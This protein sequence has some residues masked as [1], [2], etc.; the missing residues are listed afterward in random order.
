MHLVKRVKMSGM[1]KVTTAFALLALS[2]LFAPGA[3]HAASAA[4]AAEKLPRPNTDGGTGLYRLLDERSSG[5]RSAFP[6]GAVS[7]AELST[8]LW[9]ASGRNR[10]DKG[11]TVPMANGRDPYV[12]IYVLS[13]QGAYRYDGKAHA[14]VALAKGDVRNRISPDG[15]AAGAP[16]LL[17]FAAD[18]AAVKEIGGNEPA[19]SLAYTAAGA[20]S[21]NIYLAAGDLGI[22]TR[23]MMTVNRDG[24]EKALR[25]AS[26]DFPICVMP[27]GKKPVKP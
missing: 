25:I 6:A 19:R 20:M 8:I 21:Q 12:N 26:D 5:T 23:Y 9:A 4:A 24:A 18:G 27:L 1:F 7:R 3:L 17:M 15:F 14:L 16:Y 2:L 13:A 22:A 11:W 10:D